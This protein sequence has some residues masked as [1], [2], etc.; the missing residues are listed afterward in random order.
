MQKTK[1]FLVLVCEI[2]AVAVLKIY[3]K[4]SLKKIHVE[5]EQLNPKLFFD[6]HY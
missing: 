5:L 1:I 6:D 3:L 2:L 4:H